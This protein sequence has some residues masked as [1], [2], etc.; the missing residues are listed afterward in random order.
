MEEHRR[1]M[2]KA[3]PK[4]LAVHNAS[5]PRPVRNTQT[6][7]RPEENA[8]ATWLERSFGWLY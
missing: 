3:G 2:Q 7:V 6:E 4:I 8:D 5:L 1:S